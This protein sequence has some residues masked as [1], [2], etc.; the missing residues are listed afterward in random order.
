MS[1]IRVLLPAIAGQL[2]LVVPNNAFD[3]E[4][5]V[6]GMPIDDL[7]AIEAVR[8]RV[9]SATA[10]ERSRV[11][12]SARYAGI[13]KKIAEGLDAGRQVLEAVPVQGSAEEYFA[14]VEAGVAG[15]RPGRGR[16]RH[17][18]GGARGGGARS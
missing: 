16:T 2:T 12:S 6:T 5:G 11:R 17:G 7:T 15:A 9:L 1:G 8:E 14:A 18:G 13:S 4:D 10:S 3:L